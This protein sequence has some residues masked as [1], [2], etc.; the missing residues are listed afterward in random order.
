MFKIRMGVPEMKDLWD[1]LSSKSKHGTLT[2]TEVLLYKKLGKALRFL[3]ANPQHPG[4]ASHD[5]DALSHRY[6]EKVWQSYLE[7][8]TPAAGRIFWVYGPGRGEIT[9]IGLEPHPED[10]KSSGYANVKLSGTE[11]GKS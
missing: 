7:N 8:R 6:G 9:V 10:E 2:K 1:T 3:S 11:S 5:I 4:L